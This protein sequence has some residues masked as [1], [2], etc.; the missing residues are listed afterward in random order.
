LT[1]WKQPKIKDG[2]MLNKNK[3]LETAEDLL[4][5][6]DIVSLNAT[7]RRDTKSAV[8]RTCEMAGC[9][10]LSLRLEVPVLRETVR[11][12]RPAAH[13]VSWKTWANI[14]SLFRRTLELAGVIDRMDRGVALRHPLW[15]PLMRSIAHDKRLAGGLAAFA[16]W[17][18]ARDISPH[19]ISKAVL[20]EF[21]VWL[22][23]RTL[24]PKPRDVVRRIPHV[25]NEARRTMS[26]WPP[27][28]LAT[29]SFKP[30]QK[31]LRFKDLPESFQADAQSYLAMRADPDVFDERPNAPRRPLAKSTLQAQSEHLRLSASVLV[32]SGVSLDEINSLAD[33]VQPERFKAI[34]RHYHKQANGQPNAFAICIA[35]TLIQVARHYVGV[36]PEQLAQLKEI[37]SKLP[38]VPLEPTAKNNAL[39]RQMESERLRA[40]LLF[41]P[42]DVISDVKNNLAKGRLCL[43]DAQVAITIDLQLAIGLRPQNLSTL[44]WQRHFIEPDG[45]RGRLLLHIPAAEMKSR[46]NDFDVEIPEDVARRLR[47]YRRDILSRIKADPNG[48]LFVTKSGRRKDQRTLTIQITKTIERRLGI[49]MTP[50][51][52]RHLNGNAYLEE[53]PHDT[54]TARLMLGHAWTKTT[55]IYVGSSTRRASRAY[56]RF[57]FEQR[58]ALKLKR[59]PRPGRKSKPSSKPSPKPSDGGD[60]PCES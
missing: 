12:I 1:L 30:P 53:N 19:K 24:C 5:F 44:N 28:E 56:N 2:I 60:A 50:H 27:L 58:E 13:G 33:L 8:K 34:L 54:E 29:V 10:P 7:R 11:K 16:N 31:H 18:A 6:L 9:A 52:F 47:W 51:Q 49:H 14:R 37:A 42:E 4:G 59:K 17:C 45:P 46:R 32:E 36:T 20:Q 21:H 55:R 15:G 23:T 22:E 41:L 40:K 25:W 57:L 38:A 3:S 48:D 43:V 35:Q 26:G 39:S